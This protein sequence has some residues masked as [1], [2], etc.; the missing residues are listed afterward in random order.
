MSCFQNR[1]SVERI[2]FAI[3]NRQNRIWENWSYGEYSPK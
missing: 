1:N 2:I 3:F